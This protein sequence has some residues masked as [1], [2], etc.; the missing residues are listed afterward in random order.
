MRRHVR[1]F[2]QKKFRILS[3]SALVAF[4]TI[5]CFQFDRQ[6]AADILFVENAGFENIQGQSTNNEFTFGT[7]FGWQ[8]HDPNNIVPQSG[9]TLGTL[10]P[11]GIDYFNSTAPEGQRVAIMYNSSN[12]GNGEYGLYQELSDT[13]QG[14]TLYQLSVQVG[15]IASGNGFDLE[16][17]PGYRVDLMAGGQVIASDNNQL[18]I[19]EAEWDLSM[20]EFQ[21]GSS[22]ALLG[23]NLGIRLVNLNEIPSGFTQ[24]TSPDLEVDFDDVVLTAT[25]VPEPGSFCLLFGLAVL[26]FWKRR[27]P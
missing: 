24:Q 10:L 21:T 3:T 11:N 27:K 1:N 18:I 9:V 23:Q 20:I 16:E 25:A 26:S 12:E 4:L 6:V 22:H 2:S 7:P 13:L 19:P 15:N 5:F 8:R 14:N 17:F